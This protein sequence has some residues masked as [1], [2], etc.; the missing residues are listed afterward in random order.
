MLFPDYKLWKKINILQLLTDILLP[1]EKEM[2]DKC[3]Q[4]SD[5][6]SDYFWAV[7]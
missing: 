4:D 6:S 5:A 1:R 3:K 7:L 2:Q